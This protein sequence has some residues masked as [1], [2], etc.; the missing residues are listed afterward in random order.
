MKRKFV[1]HNTN[2]YNKKQICFTQ[3]KCVQENTNLFYT[4]QMRTIKANLFYT[5][6]MRTMKTQICFTQHK[7]VQ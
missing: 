4:T 3:N 2:A 6:Q 5:T 7:C 1:L